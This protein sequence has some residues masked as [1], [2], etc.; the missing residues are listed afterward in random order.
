M[1]SHGLSSVHAN[2]EKVSVSSGVSSHKY[3]NPGES[4]PHPH[5]LFFLSTVIISSEA[6]SMNTATLEVRLQYMDLGREGHKNS[7]H[8][9]SK[10]C[11]QDTCRQETTKHQGFSYQAC[12]L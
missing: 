12:R 4:G 1:S 11:C 7:V 2:E 5:D 6:P 3:T 9:N 8:N 10:P